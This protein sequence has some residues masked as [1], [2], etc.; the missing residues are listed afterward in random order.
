[1]LTLFGGAPVPYSP[2]LGPYV[3]GVD[4]LATPDDI[5]T[6]DA[7]TARL[8]LLVRL[9][10]VPNTPFTGGFSFRGRWQ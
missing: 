8:V 9:S 10:E 2:R 6:A 1:M 3:H 5:A 4:R 7:L